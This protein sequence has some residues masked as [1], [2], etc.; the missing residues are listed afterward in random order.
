MGRTYVFGGAGL[1]GSLICR[2]LG[3]VSVDTGDATPDLRAD[4][5]VIW[6]ATRPWP[7]LDPGP[8]LDETVDVINLF[9]QCEAAGVKRLIF[10]SSF[11]VEHYDLGLPDQYYGRARGAEN[12]YTAGKRAGEALTLAFAH[13]APDRAGVVVRIGH[14]TSA[15]DSPVP[16]VR[17]TEDEVVDIYR[18]ALA[19]PDGFT[20]LRGYATEAIR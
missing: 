16:Q 4:D 10:T 11:N 14:F 5:T 2:E 17:M 12:Y 19:A 18:E 3:L 8:R 9:R 20:L 13:G 6:A 1:I 7:H 15:A